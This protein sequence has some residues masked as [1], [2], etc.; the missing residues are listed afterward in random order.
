M[1]G[2]GLISTGHAA[3][4]GANDETGGILTALRCSLL[5]FLTFET[6]FTSTASPSESDSLLRFFCPG[7][8]SFKLTFTFRSPGELPAIPRNL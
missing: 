5:T 6:S 2:R 4:T 1:R 7:G 3:A 8:V